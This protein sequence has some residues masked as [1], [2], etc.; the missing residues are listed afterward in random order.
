MVRPTPDAKPSAKAMAPE[1]SHPLPHHRLRKVNDVML[2]LV[3]KLKGGK[4][5]KKFP[6]KNNGLGVSVNM[7]S[8]VYLSLPRHGIKKCHPNNYHPDLAI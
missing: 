7:G 8:R 1:E 6:H 4:K 5:W 2:Y 3:A